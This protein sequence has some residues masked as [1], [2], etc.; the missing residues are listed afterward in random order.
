MGRDKALIEVA[1]VPLVLRVAARV[2]QVADPVMLAPGRPGR[3][4]NLGYREVAD[5]DEGAGP[6]G[7]L[8][9]GLDASP[10]RLVA[11]V[12]VDMPHASPRLMAML[13]DLHDGEDA[14]V[15]VTEAGVQPLHAVYA[16]TALPTIWAAL[17]ADRLALHAVLQ[18]LKVRLVGRD[19]W[20]RADPGGR[21]AFNV[22]RAEDLVGLV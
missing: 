12:G 15:P 14:V 13:A 21:F 10:H 1:G 16:T 17:R 8:A 11:V 6:L 22:N 5:A 20:M 4:G 18:E 19:E 2:A 7:G 9:A 3:L